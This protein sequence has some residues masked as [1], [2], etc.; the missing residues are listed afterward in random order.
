M[1]IAGYKARE[2][3]GWR[4]LPPQASEGGGEGGG[5]C[6]REEWGERLVT[7]SF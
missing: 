4:S 2:G 5:D 7:T 3:G 6:A 1:G